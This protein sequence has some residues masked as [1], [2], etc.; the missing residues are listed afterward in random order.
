MNLDDLATLQN[1]DSARL[2]TAIDALPS[3]ITAAWEAG[4]S[5]QLPETWRTP[6]HAVL[7]GLGPALVAAEMAASRL[8][9]LCPVPLLVWGDYDAPAFVGPESVVLALSPDGDDDETLSAALM[10]RERGAHVA[11]LT[12]GGDL[13]AA[14]HAGGWPAGDLCG[15]ASAQAASGPLAVGLLGVLSQLGLGPDLSAE[16][17]GAAAAVSDQQASFRAEAPVTR[18]PAKRM[19]GQFMDRVPLI[20]AAEPLAP[21]ARHWKNQVNLLAKAPAFFEVVPDMDHNSIAGTLQPESLVSKYMVLELRTT[22]AHARAQW[23]A[24]QTRTVFMTA[25]FNTDA[26]DGL[27]P[28]PLAHMLTALHYGDYTAFYLAMCYGIDPRI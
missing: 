27:G 25:G 22:H 20:I 1:L 17:Q 12:R 6:R 3:Q 28:S 2:L 16:V 10:A 13:A 19:A 4:A 21:V 14:A 24:D 8:A 23:L 9:G 7:A 15:G 18:N 26:I 5:L 11:A